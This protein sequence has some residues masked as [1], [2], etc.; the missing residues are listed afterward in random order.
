[1]GIRVTLTVNGQKREVEVEPNE[2]LLDVLRNKLGIKSVKAG[3]WRGECGICTV[4]M[5]D[6][7]VKSCL[8]LAAEADGAEII[9]VEGLM[10][11]G[12]ISPLQKAFIEHGAIQ[13]GFCTSGFLLTAHWLLSKNPDVTREE[14]IEAINGL[15]CRCTGYEQIIEAI[16]A[17]TKYYKNQQ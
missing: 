15:I 14:V 5:N 3:C 10:K 17:A 9:T 11:D 16:L 12:R 8:V 7:P 6:K 13:C 4:I 1:M 2:T